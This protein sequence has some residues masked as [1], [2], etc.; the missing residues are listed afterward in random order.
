V[1]ESSDG[2]ETVQT[3]L[4][5]TLIGMQEAAGAGGGGETKSSKSLKDLGDSFEL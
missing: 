5:P 3:G 4:G 1:G 2:V